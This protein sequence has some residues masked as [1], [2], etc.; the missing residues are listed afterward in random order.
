[1]ALMPQYDLNPI[2]GRTFD[3]LSQQHALAVSFNIV[4]LMREVLMLSTSI[5]EGSTRAID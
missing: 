2:L 4:S 1:M 3:P 5:L